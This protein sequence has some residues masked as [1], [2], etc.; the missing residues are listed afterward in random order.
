MAF[1]FFMS[2]IC[3]ALTHIL[4]LLSSALAIRFP[5][6]KVLK[7]FHMISVVSVVGVQFLVLASCTSNKW[8]LLGTLTSLILAMWCFFMAGSTDPG[9]VPE[10]WKDPRSGMLRRAKKCPKTKVDKPDNAHYCS[11]SNK[12]V[13]GKEHYFPLISNCVGFRNYR[14][15]FLMLMY[16]TIAYLLAVSQV[17]WILTHIPTGTNGVLIVL[18][19]WAGYS[20]MCDGI[21]VTGLF[22]LHAVAWWKECT[23]IEFSEKK[24]KS[25]HLQKKLSLKDP[26]SLLPVSAPETKEG[27]CNFVDAQQVEESSKTDHFLKKVFMVCLADET[28][29]IATS[30]ATRLTTRI[31]SNVHVVNFAKKLQNRAKQ[32][33]Q[34]L[35]VERV[36]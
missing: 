36:H 6:N 17:P 32:R 15:F 21:Y 31:R 16:A 29:E 10:D 11:I 20:V 2:V 8:M 22:C 23:L 1:F 4:L 13:V 5:Q 26:M 12:C 7:K 27:I 14:F 33:A 19:R 9:Y 34:D 25:K 30:I 24:G 18:I 35:R 3:P 28:L